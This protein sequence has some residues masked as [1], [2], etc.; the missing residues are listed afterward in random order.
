[1]SRV[2]NPR[3]EKVMGEGIG[4]S[5]IENWYQTEQLTKR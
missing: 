4:K 1:M 5:E 3:E 2:V